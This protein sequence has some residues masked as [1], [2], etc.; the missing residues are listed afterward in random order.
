[1]TASTARSYTVQQYADHMN[2]KTPLVLEWIGNGHL[3]VIDISSRPGSGRPS[4]RIPPE[5]AASFEASR[6]SIP[7]VKRVRGRKRKKSVID[8]SLAEFL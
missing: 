2:V 8:P 6:M 7:P 3:Q 4:W 1:M 5:N